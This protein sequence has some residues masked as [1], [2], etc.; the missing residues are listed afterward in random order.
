MGR[1]DM[2]TPSIS[3]NRRPPI[4]APRPLA[5]V[6]ASVLIVVATYAWSALRYAPPGEAR[7]VTPSNPIAI[8]GRQ[9]PIDIGATTIGTLRQIDHSIEAWSKNLA[10]NPKDFLAATNLSLLYHGRG[11]LTYDLADHE[12]ALAAA[13]T[14]LAIEPTYAPARA[15]EATI[16]FTL[17]DFR[18]AYVAADALVRDDPSQSGAL[19]TRFDAE[20]ELGRLDDARTDLRRL[21]P[22]GGPA[23]LIRQARL[24]SA[25]GDT[26]GALDTARRARDAA[27]DDDEQ[28]IGFYAYAVG[29]YG[30]LA[31]DAATARTG[32]VA[33]I[34]ARSSDIAALVGLARIDAFEGNVDA[35]IDGLRRATAIAPQPEA[36]CLLGDLEAMANDPDATKAYETVRFIERLGDI[37]SKTFDRQLLRFE[38]DHAGASDDVLARAKTSLEGRPGWTGHDTVAWALYRLGRFDEAAAEIAAARALGADDARLRFHEGAIELGR[39][40]ALKGKASLESALDLGPALDPIERAEATRLLGG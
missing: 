37:Q 36:L 2:T 13:R 19:A 14:A 32:F 26:A 6:F 34:D 23:I 38:L 11:R 31:G 30:R 35:A 25:T 16:L 3:S 20:L 5:I 33:A 18:G 29:E 28:D 8:P 39:G 21:G 40:D 17:H 27:I 10:A 15:S 1:N 12:R 9:A 24:D 7:P 4:R 22:I